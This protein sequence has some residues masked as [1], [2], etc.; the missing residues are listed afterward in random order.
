MIWQDPQQ[1]I[2][3][4]TVAKKI[5]IHKTT[6]SSNHGDLKNYMKQLY[7]MLSPITYLKVKKE[8]DKWLMLICN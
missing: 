5:G 1:E 2:S 8:I 3:L 6:L 4:E 7:C